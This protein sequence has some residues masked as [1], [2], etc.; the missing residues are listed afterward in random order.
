M[1]RDKG[2]VIDYVYTNDLQILKKKA[3]YY[4]AQKYTRVFDVRVE[5][6]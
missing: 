5:D 2:S 1:P 3:R 6:P 4:T